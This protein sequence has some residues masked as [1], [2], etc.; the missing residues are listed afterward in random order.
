MLKGEYPVVIADLLGIPEMQ[1]S[2]GPWMSAQGTV[3]AEWVKLVAERLG[4]PYSDKVSTMRALVETVGRTW[5]PATMA[6][7]MTQSQGGGNISTPAFRALLEGLETSE[8][9]SA[10]AGYQW[11][12]ESLVYQAPLGMANLDL[13]ERASRAHA[14]TQNLLASWLLDRGYEPLSPLS[15]QPAF[16]L[17][18]QEENGLVVAEVKSL[19]ESQELPQLRLGLGQ[20]LDYAFVLGARPVLVVERQPN[21]RRWQDVCASRGVALAWPGAFDQLLQ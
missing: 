8:A 3:M 1:G 15:S 14:V 4:V 21:V 11:A 20:A 19:P 16:D 13:Q 6:S 5:D 9:T 2:A 12:D 17:A 10:L 7:T 18:W